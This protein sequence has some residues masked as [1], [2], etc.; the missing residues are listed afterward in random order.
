MLILT[1]PATQSRL[2]AAIVE[3]IGLNIM[4][5]VY[6]P[7]S[8]DAHSTIQYAEIKLKQPLTM[9]HNPK[10]G[11]YFNANDKQVHF[12]LSGVLINPAETLIPP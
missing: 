1:K 4:G 12:T 11:V 8:W 3:V 6:I 10:A 7:G 9:Y 2:D 5:P